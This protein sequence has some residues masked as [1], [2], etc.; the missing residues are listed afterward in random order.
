MFAVILS[1]ALQGVDAYIVRVEAD[2]S[3]GLPALSIV[4][5]PD[6]AVRES[7]DRVSAA[8]RNSGFVLPPNRLTVNLSPADVRKEGTAFDLA[9]AMAILVVSGQVLPCEAD[10]LLLLGELS[11]DGTL[12][13]VPGCVAIAADATKHS[14]EG[15]IVPHPNAPEAAVV[16]SVAVYG[17]ANLREA[18]ELF[19]KPPLRRRVRVDVEALRRAAK[20]F[21]LDYA[22][23]KG[24]ESA[25]RALEIAAVGGHNVLMFGPPGSGKT[26]L[27]QRL[28]SILP[29][30]T[31]EE[32][33]ETTKV[34]SVAGILPSDAPLVTTR[35]FRSPH[36]TVSTAGL[37]GG[38]NTPRP[39][40]VSLAHNGV[41]FLDELPEFQR[42][43][44]EALRQ[45]LEDGMTTIARAWGSL[46][47]PARTMFVAAM[48]P[49]PCG[50]LGDAKGRCQ[51][52]LEQIRRY[53][54]RI[55]GPLLDRIDLHVEVPAVSYADLY[56]Q[57]P[58]E[59]SAVIRER[60]Q[61]ARAR[62]LRRF[63]GTPIYANAMMGPQ[64][65]SEFCQI[66]AEGE[67][68]LVSAR[69]RILSARSHHRVLKVARSIADLD[70]S[71][72][73]RVEHI[74]EALSY[75]GFEGESF[76]F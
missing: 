53:R 27:A 10:R 28:P 3:G 13:P 43:A 55:S 56:S 66:D 23:V 51:C 46:T 24:Q 54:A 29:D 44:L 6:N 20:A 76:S 8:I 19:Q 39:G 64:H 75:R 35:P 31:P 38:G 62:A 2:L 72:M 25:K 59:S 17:V 52:S 16:E 11:L 1:S 30:M 63:Q 68:L 37:V 9:I 5:L 7:R 4:G 21:P 12:R 36:H 41:L 70:D 67:L 32:A 61:R 71:D 57:V 42:N 18:A 15:L 33:L 50:F 58:G 26:M 69:D 47:F 73:I 34:H 45:P 74:A 60:V 22:D 49:C 40:E 65:I 14:M 48:N